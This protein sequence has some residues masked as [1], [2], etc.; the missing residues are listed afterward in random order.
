MKKKNA[1]GT[2]NTYLIALFSFAGWNI[3]FWRNC[4]GRLM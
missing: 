2:S 3:K 4:N 1:S